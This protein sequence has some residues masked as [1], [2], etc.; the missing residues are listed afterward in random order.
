M[1]LLDPACGRLA[2]HSEGACRPCCLPGT[3]APVG[4]CVIPA[5]PCLGLMMMETL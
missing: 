2:L 5:G 1:A 3:G 4:I